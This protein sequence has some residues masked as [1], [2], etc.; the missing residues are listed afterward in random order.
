MEATEAAVGAAPVL[1]RE[2][3]RTPAKPNN[4]YA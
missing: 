2:L 1:C 3:D 4:N